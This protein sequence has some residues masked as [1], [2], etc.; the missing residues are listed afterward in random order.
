[1]QI[2]LLNLLQIIIYLTIC[3]IK[4]WIL[5]NLRVINILKLDMAIVP[6]ID[7]RFVGTS[8]CDHFANK[9]YNSKKLQQKIRVQAAKFG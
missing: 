2:V 8:S 7:Q 6:A 9:A 3:K 1:M 5:N 4:T